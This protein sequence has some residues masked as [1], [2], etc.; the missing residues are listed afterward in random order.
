VEGEKRFGIDL[1][2]TLTRARES[3]PHLFEGHMFYLS[4]NLSPVAYDTL[5]NAI[6]SAGGKVFIS[7]LI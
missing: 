7:F 5:R 6:D 3:G 4:P 2:E 1:Q